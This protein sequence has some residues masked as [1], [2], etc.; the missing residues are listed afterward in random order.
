MKFAFRAIVGLVLL[1]VVAVVLAT[2]FV[3]DIVEKAVEKGGT[4]ALGVDTTIEAADIG[5]F[6]GDF[7]LHA[8]AIDNPPGFQKPHFMT[9][10]DANLEV[11]L[12][13]LL[14]ETVEVPLI[15]IDG[16]TLD[17]EQNDQGT[18]YDVLMKNLERLQR[19]TPPGEEQ[20]EREGAGKKILLR[21]IVVRNVRVTA[22]IDTKIAGQREITY[23]LP[24]LILTDLGT[25]DEA[26]PMA[27]QISLIVQK[28]LAA[29]IQS[30]RDQLPQELL[31][32][33]DARLGELGD[34]LKAE[35]PEQIPDDLKEKA[36]E[37]L[38]GAGVNL[39]GVGGDLGKQADEAAKKAQEAIEGIDVGGLLGGKKKPKTPPAE[40]GG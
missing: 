20:P 9:L 8:F 31:N 18:N 27:E 40:G 12:A 6:S 25:D 13:S 29:A 5:V 36:S 33:L 1:L 35:L 23:N 37:L 15:V 39:E 11:E 17:I 24:E 10:T 7:G 28:L 22:D 16:F 34:R 30:G 32:D 38:D 3:D 26:R 4:Y 2:V 14:K 21:E 19:E